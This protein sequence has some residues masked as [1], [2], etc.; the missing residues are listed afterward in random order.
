MATKLLGTVLQ[1]VRRS[2]L[3]HDNAGHTDGTLL[4]CFITQ[5]DEAAFE[6]LVRRHGPMVLG[7]CRRVLRNEAD[8]EDAFQAT[9]LVLV[10]RAGSI[11]PRGMVGNWL[12]GV[13]HNTAR[14]A[15]AM[16]TRM[17]TREREAGARSKPEAVSEDWQQQQ[18]LLDQELEALPDKYRAPIVLCDL[19]GK[20]I[21]DAA[22]HLGCP[23]G[24]IGTRLARG[25]SMLARR[26]ARRG[27]TLSGALIAAFLSQKAA[28]AP[29]PLPLVSSTV[30]AASLFTV[31]QAASGVV[32]AKVAAL[33]EGV[34]KTMLLTK[35]KIATAV[36]LAIAGLSAGLAGLNYDAQAAESARGEQTQPAQDAKAEQ[37][38]SQPGPKDKAVQAQI[39]KVLKA[40]GGEE[41]LGKLKTFTFK[42]KTSP[43]LDGVIRDENTDH[44]HLYVQ[45]PD[46]VRAEISR[47]G[48]DG[49]KLIVV[50]Y[51]DKNWRKLNDGETVSKDRGMPEEVVK[52]LGPKAILKLKDPE[53][54][55]SLVGERMVGDTGALLGDRAAVC[56]K[57]SR[58]DRKKFIPLDD[59]GH[60][61]AAD[62]VLLYFDKNSGLLLKQEL[63]DNQLHF[64]IF[65]TEYK[66]FNGIAVAQKRVHKTD[67]EVNY[68]SEVEFN[69]VDALDA[70]LFQKP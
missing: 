64:E 43:V 59:Y 61:G 35:L 48:A 18:E 40:H 37:P 31:G 15:K 60:G 34:L 3:C 45:L 52:Y 13:A 22:R 70:K 14:K 9:F 29:V 42:V 49:G 26:L 46:K 65:Y 12:Y 1:N 66:T 24:T 53:M 51:K 69:I 67:G 17:R 7:V 8:A 10:R 55:V 21:K 57:L 36:L 23:L 30:K 50:Y 27:L 62:E 41:I 11:R 4:E 54:I 58:K 32:G 38:A 28:S 5:Q 68:R 25:R 44:H 47:D 16:N 6:A 20:S 2:V 33:T 19:E 56:I 39:A 63:D